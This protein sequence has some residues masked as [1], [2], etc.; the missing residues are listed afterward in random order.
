M[1][2]E[3]KGHSQEQFLRLLMLNDKR[4][5][6]YILS[7]VPNAAD[8]DDIMQEASAVMWRK[9]S[10][11]IPGMDFVAW[12]LTI[13]RYQ[14]LS[15]FKKKKSRKLCLSEALAESLE[16]EVVRTLPEMDRRMG[17]MKQCIDKLAQ[18]DRYILKLRYEKDL[19]LENIGAHISKSTRATY[20]ALVRIHRNLLQCIKQTLAE[21]AAQ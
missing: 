3:E 5:Y 12:A 4:I 9:F 2:P 10:S 7:F 20:Y 18:M 6:A 14:I 15:Y 16:Q 13:A 11:F 8:A 17:A 1:M 19:T 21:E